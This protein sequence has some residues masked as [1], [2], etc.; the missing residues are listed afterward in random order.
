MDL[1]DLFRGWGG[2]RP[3]R[4][5]AEGLRARLQFVLMSYAGLGGIVAVGVTVTL[6]STP[7]GEQVLHAAQEAIEIPAGQL[8]LAFDRESPASRGGEPAREA[9]SLPPAA[10]VRPM[11]ER[12]PEE[13]QSPLVG[14]W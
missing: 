4:I 3:A 8:E 14:D 1:G 12:A 11:P 13:G 10:V 9:L 6:A 7:V 2:D 5:R